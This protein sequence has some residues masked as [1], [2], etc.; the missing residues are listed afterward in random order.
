MMKMGGQTTVTCSMS[1]ASLIEHNRFPETYILT[2]CEYGSVELGPDFQLKVTT[3]EGTLSKRVVPPHYP[4]ADPAYDIIHTSIVDCN[5][6]LLQALQTGQ[7]AETSGADNLK[8]CQLYFGAYES[9]A[10]GQVIQIK[11]AE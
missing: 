1:Y 10:R 11:A 7:T 2:E 9:A 3:E 6:S 5:A 4:W 8:T